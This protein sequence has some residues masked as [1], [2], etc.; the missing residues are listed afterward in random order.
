MSR[1]TTSRRFAIVTLGCRVNQCES[2]S[3]AQQLKDDGWTQAAPDVEPDL[4]IVNTCTV[5]AKAAMQSRQAIRRIRRDHPETRLTVTG[6]YAQVAPEEIRR[7]DGVDVICGNTEKSRIPEKMTG[8]WADTV[9]PH[10]AVFA[11]DRLRS[12]SPICVPLEGDRT[13]PVLKIQDG[14][15]SFCTYCIV[16]YARGRSR[17][18]PPDEVMAHIRAMEA[19]GFHEVVLSGIHLGAYGADLHP[20]ISFSALLQRIEN[21]TAVERVRLSSIE[22]KELTSDVLD[23]IAASSRFCP[24]FH[25]PLQSGDNEILQK[26]GRPYS[27]ESF[28]KLVTSIRRQ[29]PEAAIGADVLVGFPGETDASFDRTFGLIERLPVT[30]LHVFPFSPRPGTPAFAFP[31]QV[32]PETLQD[33]C[34]RLRALGRAKRAA[35]LEQVVGHPASA[36]VEAKR[37]PRTGRLKATTKNYVTVLIEGADSLKNR[38]VSC[39]IGRRWGEASVFGELQRPDGEATAMKKP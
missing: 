1:Q 6:C 7:I 27:V 32:P 34:R 12:F 23:L 19:A 16:P 13:R 3:L 5:T 25:I 11:M 28:E 39:R 2:D 29:M 15:N 17:S 4:V 33:R 10:L 14:C 9:S 26:M 21:E 31:G 24:H 20:A 36:L 38:I 30:Y 37:D 35:F 22:P 8:E 18:M